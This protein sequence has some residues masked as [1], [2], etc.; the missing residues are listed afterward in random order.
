MQNLTHSRRLILG[1][2]RFLGA[3]AI[4]AVGAVHLQQYLGADYR[5]IP[6]IGTLFMLNA[7]GAGIVGLGLL[8]PVERVLPARAAQVW[9]GVVALIAVAIAAGSLIALFIS[10]S[11][12]LFGF[13]E[14]GYRTPIVVAIIAE[15]ATI[16]LLAPVIAVSLGRALSDRADAI[17]R[18]GRRRD[19]RP[20]YG[21][22]R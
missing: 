10:E 16:L 3:L 5:A 6:T 22:V 14:S 19:A 20:N 8:V 7:I 4:I 12:S 9:I 1:P 21:P 17:K 18:R 2:M 13:S 15:A 11:G